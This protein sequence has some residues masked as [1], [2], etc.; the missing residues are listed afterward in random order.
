MTAEALPAQAQQLWLI[1]AMKAIEQDV[2]F[3]VRVLDPS[4][5]SGTSP[6]NP[7]NSATSDVS[8][9]ETEETEY[10]II[11]NS[12]DGYEANQFF[13]VVQFK[14]KTDIIL[15]I[16]D[17]W[18]ETQYI[19]DL[20]LTHDGGDAGHFYGGRYFTD[21]GIFDTETHIYPQGEP[22]AGRSVQIAA[23]ECFSFVDS[24]YY[25]NFRIDIMGQYRYNSGFFLQ[26]N[27]EADFANDYNLV[28]KTDGD[29]KNGDLCRLQDNLPDITFIELLKIFA[30]VSGRVLA[31]DDVRGIYFDE[32]SFSDWGVKE[33]GKITKRGEVKRVFSD[34]VKKNIINYKSE[35]GI[36]FPISTAYT[37]DN[38]NLS[39]EKVLQTIPF[40]EGEQNKDYPTQ[41]YVGAQSEEPTLAS[42]AGEDVFLQRVQLP[43]NNNIQALCDASTQIKID[44]R[45]PL[46]TY[47]GIKPDTALL[48]D[49][50]QYLWT[51]RSWQKDVAQFTL[52]RFAEMQVFS[53][54]SYT[55]TAFLK[56]TFPN[57]WVQIR[58]YGFAHPEIVEFANEDPMLVCSLVEMGVRRWLVGDG[59][60]WIE[61]GKTIQSY[62]YCRVKFIQRTIANYTSMFGQG[63]S[64]NSADAFIYAT[65]QNPPVMN[66]YIGGRVD[67]GRSCQVPINT[68]FIFEGNQTFVK[69][70]NMI[71][72]AVVQQESGVTSI[73]ATTRTA[74]IFRGDGSASNLNIARDW[75]I[76]E[77]VIENKINLFPH[78]DN[79]MLDLLTGTKYGNANTSGA[80]TI[81]YTDDAGNTILEP[82][83]SNP[84]YT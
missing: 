24:R 29:L 9:F 32:V 20:S 5:P 82:S 67:F 11:V 50:S 63:S 31:Y 69:G 60:A 25:Q 55:T 7:Y 48:V 76:G 61:S 75:W 71:T 49:N 59:A 45:M 68:P 35:D 36:L 51:E 46:L 39:D 43:K 23:G 84:W 6:V 56:R 81:E 2:T 70:T 41:V 62:D 37:I 4:Q 8:I 26:E 47:D 66:C 28:V 33:I 22:L 13:K 72:G 12:A 78:K 18:E 17:N 15:E 80:F 58:D 42:D 53:P 79:V 34:Y 40:S 30:A 27:S 57:H 83:P 54:Y 1:S 19:F 65:T 74:K 3:G 10:G 44:A 14:A 21:G 77:V 73:G 52:A 16:P 38:D 64:Y